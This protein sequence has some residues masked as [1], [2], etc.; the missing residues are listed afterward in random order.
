MSKAATCLPAEVQT[1]SVEVYA[2]GPVCIPSS[3]ALC[4]I[5]ASLLGIL[6][7]KEAPLKSHKLQATRNLD[8]SFTQ[9]TAVCWRAKGLRRSSVAWT[10]NLGGA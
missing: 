9:Q 8:L 2:L 7:L 1:H 6:S 4:L 5:V 10:C 3:M